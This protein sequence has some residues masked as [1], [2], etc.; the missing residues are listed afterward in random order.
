MEATYQPKSMSLHFH[1]PPQLRKSVSQSGRIVHKFCDS[2]N[3]DAIKANM[4]V[5]VGL[6]KKR[7]RVDGPQVLF[8]KLRRQSP[9]SDAMPSA[10]CLR[11]MAFGPWPT[12]CGLQPSACGLWPAACGLRPSA[13][14]IKM[15]WANRAIHI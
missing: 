4:M 8:P 3:C 2:G 7:Q 13:S 5:T 14:F 12:A 10:C 6:C 1:N 11:R 15:C 9:Y